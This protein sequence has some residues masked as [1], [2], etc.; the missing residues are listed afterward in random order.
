MPLVC[1]ARYALC[2]SKVLWLR[3][4]LLSG[5]DALLPHYAFAG[6]PLYFTPWCAL[7]GGYHRF[8]LYRLRTTTFTLYIP[9]LFTPPVGLP[10]H[11]I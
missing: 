8:M 3:L 6:L 1:A 2:R 7:P 5:G 11:T 10:A 9:H 4:V